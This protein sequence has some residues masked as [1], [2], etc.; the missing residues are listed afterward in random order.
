M[1][2]SLKPDASAWEAL[3][4]DA[5]PRSRL[6]GRYLYEH[7]FTAHVLGQRVYVPSGTRED[8]IDA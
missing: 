6:V 4:N 1:P 8:I 2:A 3:L 5:S 7:L